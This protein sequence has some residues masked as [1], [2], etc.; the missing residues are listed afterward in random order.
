M[1]CFRC[2]KPI[3]PGTGVLLAAA[4]RVHVRCLAGATQLKA[5]ELRSA[6]KGL[7]A[8]TE[9]LIAR[10]RAVGR[11]VLCEDPLASGAL[12]FQGERLVHA[13]CWCPPA[14]A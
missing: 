6:A 3:H 14:A 5:L 12:I 7:Q 4:R 2:A 10:A 13:A 9:A 8:E 1:T 11:C